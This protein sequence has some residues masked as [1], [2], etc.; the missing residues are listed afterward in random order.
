MDEKAANQAESARIPELWSTL[1]DTGLSEVQQVRVWRTSGLLAAGA[2]RPLPL[3]TVLH[4]PRAQTLGAVISKRWLHVDHLGIPTLI[5]VDKHKLVSDLG[6]RWV[7]ARLTPSLQKQLLP[8]VQPLQTMLRL[9]L[10]ASGT[11]I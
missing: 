6:I 11:E 1:V 3:P 5:E 8:P 9:L 2:A 4:A 7:A 10:V